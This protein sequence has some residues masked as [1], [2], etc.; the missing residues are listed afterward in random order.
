MNA[1]PEQD[2]HACPQCLKATGRHLPHSSAE[3]WVDYYRCDDCGY[4]WTIKKGT[5]RRQKSVR[6]H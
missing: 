3:A 1:T 5:D 6:P 2:G 4:I